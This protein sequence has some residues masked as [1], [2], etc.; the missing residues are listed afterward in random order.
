MRYAMSDKLYERLVIYL[1]RNDSRFDNR[2]RPEKNENFDVMLRRF[3]RDVQQSGI[4]TEI[5]KRRY[6]CKDVSR[7]IKRNSARRK[8][9]VKRMK[10]GY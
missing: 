2:E 9:E 3:F 7:E 6:H 1:A 10:R 8:A 5:K 4:L